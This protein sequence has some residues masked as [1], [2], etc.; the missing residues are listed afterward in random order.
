METN[1]VT[2]FIEA[3]SQMAFSSLD[4]FNQFIYHNSFND[5]R[6]ANLQRYLS[7]ISQINPSILLVMEA[8]G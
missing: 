2:K 4:S 8:P 5:L 3:L 1:E 6:R 7:Q